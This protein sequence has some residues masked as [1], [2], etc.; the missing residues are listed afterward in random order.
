M[1]VEH[2]FQTK[3]RKKK[4][5]EILDIPLSCK[6][7]ATDTAPLINPEYQ[8]NKAWRIVKPPLIAFKDANAMP[9]VAA[10]ARPIITNNIIG[11]AGDSAAGVG[12]A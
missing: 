12:A 7:R 4:E 8:T 6:Q 9:T 1:K 10:L 11:S 2:D 5:I 3:P